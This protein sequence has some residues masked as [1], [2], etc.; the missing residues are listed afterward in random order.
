MRYEPLHLYPYGGIL[1]GPTL[2]WDVGRDELGDAMPLYL[3]RMQW[4]LF[5]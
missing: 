4:V 1:I 5:E 2:N 3:S